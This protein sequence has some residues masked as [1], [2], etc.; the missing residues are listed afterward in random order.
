MLLLRTEK[1]PDSDEWCYELLCG[2]PHK[3]SYVP[4]SVMW[5]PEAES[6]LRAS[7]VVKPQ[8]NLAAEKPEGNVQTTIAFE[9]RIRR[10]LLSSKAT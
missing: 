3:I 4:Q 8:H 6:A 5:L 10:F 2:P 7:Q 9:M 1:L